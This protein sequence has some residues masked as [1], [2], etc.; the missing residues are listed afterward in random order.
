MPSRRVTLYRRPDCHLCDEARARLE[1]LRANGLAFEVEEV[2]IETDPA[3]H[4][5]FLERIPVIELDGE[6]IS[7]L[8]LD[9]SGLRARLD[10]LSE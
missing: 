2:N 5:R 6:L 7:E 4:A 9:S 8:G 3:L 1:Q 10:T